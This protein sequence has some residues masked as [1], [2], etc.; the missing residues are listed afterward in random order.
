MRNHPLMRNA[1]R[2][3]IQEQGIYSED[4]IDAMFTE[5][6]D[7]FNPISARS[8]DSLIPIAEAKTSDQIPLKPLNIP[9]LDLTQIY[10]SESSCSDE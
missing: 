2:Q 8:Q 5:N 4:E 3:I 7:Q 1:L 10:E 6:N 9:N